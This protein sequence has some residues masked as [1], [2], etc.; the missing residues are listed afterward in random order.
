MGPFWWNEILEDFNR[1]CVDDIYSTGLK[2]KRTGTE[3]AGQEGTT[4]LI[5]REQE[6]SA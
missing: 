3:A 1:N 5:D 6:Q 4:L 2:S